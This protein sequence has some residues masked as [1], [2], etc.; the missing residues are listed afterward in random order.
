MID[1]GKTQRVA[2]PERVAVYLLYWTAFSNANGTLGF[3]DDP[4]HWDKLL[5]GK[6]AASSK[7]AETRP[8]RWR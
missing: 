7:R 2:L 8:R 1:S 4:Y 3:R 6:I 5:A